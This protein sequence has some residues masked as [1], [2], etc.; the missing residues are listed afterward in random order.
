MRMTPETLEAGWKAARAWRDQ[1]EVSGKRLVFT[2][3]CFDVLH[4]GHVRYLQEA[5]A[6]GDA[7]CV[8]INTDASVRALKGP[9]RPVN[10]AEDRAEVL[11]AL[12]AVDRVI[13]FDEERCTRAIQAVAP[14]VYAKG[15]DYTP[16]TLNAEEKA[17]LDA[18][19]AE[20]RMLQLVAGKSTTATLQRLAA[21]ADASRK[22]R[23]GVLGSGRGSTLEGLLDSIA[24]GRLPD[25]EVVVVVSDCEEARILELGRRRGIPSHH[26]D[27]GP[28]GNRF[29]IASQ[30]VACRILQAAEVDL[31]I[32]AGFMR[33]I[34]APLLKAF[35]DRILNIHPSL[36]PQFPGKDAWK[37]ALGAGVAHTGATVHVVNAEID[38]GEIVQQSSVAVLP[39]DTP[40]SLHARIQEAERILYPQAISAYWKR[41]GG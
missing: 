30:E 8:A 7:L 4:V 39:G 28:H 41:V 6:L 20:I 5:R 34:K 22:L 32:L 15:G 31:V 35:P 9:T 16:E 12:E 27:P 11:L 24:T 26:I 40:E 3:G 13:F 17:A 25:A 10:T 33:R 1:L 36:L 38:A 2:N 23:L 21:P 29:A 37:Q 19:G 18:V 14:H